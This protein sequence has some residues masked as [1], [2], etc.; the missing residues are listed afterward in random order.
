MHGRCV[1]LNTISPKRVY[2]N[3]SKHYCV[4]PYPYMVPTHNPTTLVQ[5]WYEILDPIIVYGHV[6]KQIDFLSCL[7]FIKMC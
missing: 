1:I 7:S 4:V 6:C 2:K 5:L 3:S